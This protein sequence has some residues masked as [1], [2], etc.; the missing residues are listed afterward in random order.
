M[1]QLTIAPTILT[2]DTN[3]YKALIEAYHPFA[4]RVQI[5]ISDGTLAGSA[6]VP[7]SSVW[8]PKDWT[9]DIHLMSAQ[10][11]THLPTLLKLSPS[12][13][14]LHSEAGE[15]L[16]PIIG[17]LQKDGIKTGI[18]IMKAT[19]PGVIRQ[20]IEAVDHVMIFSGD[21]GK[22]GEIGRAHV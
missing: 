16:V 6:T 17:A 1:A 20:L 21:L 9:V 2:D 22:N 10:P 7:G 18:A 19:Y 14:I 15:D 3:R 4:K 13:V 8:W 5:D 11:S 12:L